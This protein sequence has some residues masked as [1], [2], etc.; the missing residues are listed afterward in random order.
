MNTK[1]HVGMWISMFLVFF[2]LSPLLRSGTDMK[3]FVRNEVQKTQEVFG[4]STTD[5]MRSKASVAFHVYSPADQIDSAVIR[6]EG[7]R[8]TMRVVPGPGVAFTK[9]YNEYVERLVLSV[10]VVI[11]RVLNF[12]VWFLLVFPVFVAAVVDGLVQRAI[13]RAEFG[14]IR[15]AAYALTSGVVVP[16]L[17]APLI[18]LVVPVPVSPFVA[19]MWALLAI[20]P[21]SAMVSNMQPIFGRS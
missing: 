6:G 1:S 16:L 11:L 4:Q 13:K 5:W 18:Y 10:Y 9:A 12:L 7:M 17:M 21:L 3:V 19:P 14:A 20:L 8:R 2:L 15:P